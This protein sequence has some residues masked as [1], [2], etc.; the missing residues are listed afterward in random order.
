[1]RRV[2]VATILMLLLAVLIVGAL[3][4]VQA[5]CAGNALPNG[6]FEAGFSERGSGEVTVAKQWTPYWQDGPDQDKGMNRR[7]EYKAEDAN[8]FG[9]LRVREGNYAQK[10]GNNYATHHGGVYQRIGVPAGSQVSVSAWGQAWS[11][12][13]DDPK[14]ASGGSYA[15]SIGLDPTGGT[16]WTSPNIIWSARNGAL[17]TW[18]EFTLAAQAQGDAVTIY[19]R[20]DAEWPVKHNDAYFDDVC[21]TVSAP[22]PTAKPTSK[23][24]PT[25]PP[26]PAPSATPE[27]QPTDAPTEVPPDTP[28]AAPPTDT[29][30]VGAL[31]VVVFEDK[32]SNGVRDAD[33]PLLPN[34]KLT[35][36]NMQRTPVAS[37]TTQGGSE[38]VTFAS[39]EPGDY[40]LTEQDPE[41]YVSTSPNEWAVSVLAGAQKELAFGN[42]AVQAS[43]TFTAEPSATPLPPTEAPATAT[44]APIKP[45][46]RGATSMSG[47]LVAALAVLLLVAVW[48]LRA[49]E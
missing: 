33:E 10:W 37:H 14:T 23:P 28:T 30:A 49:R 4:G 39:L 45:A 35:L 6:D 24:Q 32:N 29:P 20:G 22:Q 18:V 47:L 41:G 1:M 34:A 3:P 42:R 40:I 8:R 21:L 36:F 27:P 2:S 48:L 44:P 15:L 38:Q 17:N 31:R 7:P 9:R 25:S 19:L 13:K 43:P 12:E 16:D 11:S 46:A 26:A 5:G